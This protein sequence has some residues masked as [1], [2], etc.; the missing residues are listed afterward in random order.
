MKARVKHSIKNILKIT[1]MVIMVN[2][3]GLATQYFIDYSPENEQ[4]TVTEYTHNLLK[5]KFMP[6]VVT[7]TQQFFK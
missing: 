4:Q 2:I 3:C 5:N 7:V 6:F 1:A